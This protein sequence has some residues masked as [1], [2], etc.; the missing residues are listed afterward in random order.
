MSVTYQK[1]AAFGLAQ[2]AKECFIVF[3]VMSIKS[4]SAGVTML[5]IICVKPF[6]C[7][8]GCAYLL[9][10]AIFVV[11]LIEPKD[12]VWFLNPCSVA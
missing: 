10:M 1:S 12:P 4:Y 5:N 8:L 2:L 3:R 11:V 7:P 9:V 6:S